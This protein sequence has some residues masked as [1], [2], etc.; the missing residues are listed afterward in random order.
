MSGYGW[1]DNPTCY[2]LVK[3]EDVV[4]YQPS[5]NHNAILEYFRNA[6]NAR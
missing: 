2:D 4:D 3:H 5:V 1:R 6:P